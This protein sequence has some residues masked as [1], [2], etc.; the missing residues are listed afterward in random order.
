MYLRIMR[1]TLLLLLVF[2]L[3]IGAIF[4]ITKMRPPGENHSIE[5]ADKK[6]A[7]NRIQ[8]LRLKQFAQKLKVFAGSKKFNTEVCF[9][10]DMQMHS[11]KKR[12][13]VYDLKKDSI[14]YSGLVAHGSCNTRFLL[15][16]RFSNISGG[17]CSSV[18]RYVVSYKYNGRFGSAFK[19]KGM[20]STNSNAFERNVVLHAYGCV[21]DVEPYPF[22]ICNSLGCPMVSYAFLNKLENEISRSKKPV[23]LYMFD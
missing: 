17:G 3:F 6:I 18:G 21:P 20:D 11:G 5:K 12:F 22:P 10:A 9:L 19:L 13:F 1:Y 8:H 16:S 4:Y 7:D 14:L 15:N 23:V 2:I